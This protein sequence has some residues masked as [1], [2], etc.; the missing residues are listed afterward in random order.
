MVVVGW[1]E[2]AGLVLWVRGGWRERLLF[3]C[4]ATRLEV[5]GRRAGEFVIKPDEG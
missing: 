1:C 4:E 2:H 5:F 3:V